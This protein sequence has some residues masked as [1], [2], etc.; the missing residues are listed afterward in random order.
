MDTDI[1]EMQVIQKMVSK[2][3]KKQLKTDDTP[4][5]V[6]HPKKIEEKERTVLHK[7]R[8]NEKIASMLG[9]LSSIMQ[10]KG[11]MIRS[12]IYARAQD[13]VLGTGDDITSPDDL[14]GKPNIGPTILSKTHEYLET[15]TLDIFEREKNNPVNIFTDVYGIGPKKAKEI[16]SR[17]I[18]TISELRERQ[19]DILN[20]VQKTGLKYYEDILERIPRGEIEEYETNFQTAFNKVR[21]AGSKFEIVG[22]YRRGCAT[23]G[24]IDVI[25]TSPEP[26]ILSAFV[27]ELKKTGVIVEI[28]SQGNIKTLVIAKLPGQTI[29]R[30]VDFMYTP[31]EEYPFAILYF[32]GSKGFNTVMRGHALS[33]GV[34]LNEHGIYV[35]K[36]ENPKGDRIQ[37][38]VNTER[39]IFD[40]LHMKFKKPEER[41]DGRAVEIVDETAA[42]M[43][44]P[45]R[46]KRK[47]TR[48]VKV[49]NN[50]ILP[51]NATPVNTVAELVPILKVDKPRRK[52]TRKV[53]LDNNKEKTDL[54]TAL[55][56]RVEMPKQNKISENNQAT[57]NIELF[58]TNGMPVIDQLSEAELA[59]MVQV[60]NDVYYNTNKNLLTDN[61]FDI[62]KEYMERTFPKNEVLKEIGAKVEK[63]KVVLP[64][65]MP[66][67]DKIKPD[68]TALATWMREYDGPYVLSCK[69]DGVSGMYSTEGD[70]PKLYTRGDGTVGQ[71]ITH[72]ID[73][74]NLPKEKGV[75]IR[76]EFIIP[77]HIFEKK[78]RSKFANARNLVA[79]IINSKTIG[80]KAKDL[81]FVAYEMIHPETN[82][83]D[84][85]EKMA[86]MD[87][88]TVQNE[89]TDTLT[90]E[91]LSEKLLDW[92]SN[93]E[94]EIDGVIVANDAIYSRTAAN[95]KHA[96]AFKMVISDQVAEVKVVD[97]LWNA[98]KSGY[99]KP[100]VR[101]EPV[102]L[103][104]VTIEYA[105]GFNASFIETNKIGVGATVQIIRSGDVIPHI[106]SVVVPAEN[107]KMPSIP[108]HWTDSHV[109]IILDNVDEDQNVQEK[110]ITAFF[111]TTGNGIGVDG[112]SSGN[113]RRIM[114]SGYTTIANIIR[115]TPADLEKVDG[116]KTKMVSKIY[117]GIRNRLDKASLID[118]MAA[119]NMFGRGIGRR[120]IEPILQAHPNILI[121][122]SSTEDKIQK[123]LAV[124]GIGKENATSFATNIPY[125]MEFIKDIGQE[126]KLS[127]API[128][129]VEENQVITTEEPQHYL[130]GKHVVMT[131]V[132]DKSIEEHLNRVGGK[133]DNIIGKKTDILIVRDTLDV[134]NKTKYA[135]ENNI[136]VMTPD[137]YRKLYMD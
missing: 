71:D 72:F 23:S 1:E 44:Q 106:K 17:G 137:E 104:G 21:T 3:R 129:M 60:A 94:Y 79:G 15:G 63:N 99:L 51:T 83:S 56:K 126:D 90:N 36:D 80:E 131:K 127:S 73:V 91:M 130:Y 8:L 117:D 114:T 50:D 38:I 112:L 49:M 81:H 32:T 108:Y 35:K 98:S 86:V 115:M 97:V 68:T 103:G 101:I 6:I 54:D 18:T 43:K 122:P 84:Q 19:S 66:S 48:K 113:V 78:Y 45:I 118:I 47:Y 14:K 25:I 88:E 34:S 105:T 29:A 5:I 2:E 9:R 121:D 41:T 107:A 111:S 10:K 52:Y 4:S 125:F 92:R 11:D 123:L 22:S 64:Y 87:Y 16:V 77:K 96:F 124:S 132:R 27:E 58:K 7:D 61:E 62:I 136:P 39:D 12:R 30:R 109:D 40:Y 55:D 53:R 75:V 24:D 134:S 128:N 85:M 59:N 93:Y 70:E 28:L 110:K 100:R 33:R 76:G 82:P 102:R 26:T 116:F 120:R 13:T 37:S 69:L 67:M 89:R 133:M 119:S 42:P 20:N 46:T 74:L 135:K 57:V 31:P 95:P 65:N